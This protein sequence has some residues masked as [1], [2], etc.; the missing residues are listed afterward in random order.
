MRNLARFVAIPMMFALMLAVL[1]VHPK[2]VT[3]GQTLGTHVVPCTSS[4]TL[5]PSYLAEYLDL[6]CAVSSISIPS[7]YGGQPYRLTVNSDGG[8]LGGMPA[9]MT[10]DFTLSA[11]YTRFDMKYDTLTAIWSSL[12]VGKVI[13]T[14]VAQLADSSNY[15]TTSQVSSMAPV[16]SVNGQTGAVAI[17][18]TKGDTGATGPAGPQGA[19]G[20]AGANGVQGAT[21]PS[22]SVGAT[23][24]SGPMGNAG[25]PGPTGASGATGSAGASG[26]AGPTGGVGPQGVA[27]A[28]GATGAQGLVGATGA[29]GST[30]PTGSVG[31]IGATGPTGATGNI[32]ATGLQGMAGIQGATGLAGATGAAGPTGLSG[33]TGSTGATGSQ[34]PSGTTG[35]TGATGASGIGPFSTGTWPAWLT[36]SVANSSTTPTLSVA[37]SAIPNSA[38][39][40]SSVTI[41]GTSCTLGSS[42]TVKDYLSGTTGVITGTLLALGGQDTGTATVTGATAGTPC[43]ASTTDGTNPSSSVV[44]SCI[45]TAANTAT[46]YET[47]LAAGTPLSKAFNIRVF[48]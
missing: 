37:A 31:P 10:G 5:N 1:L 16:Q 26:P 36:P 42:C 7:G 8:S 38:L 17:T 48:P 28:V 40:S 19:Q 35:A 32:G 14:T 23:G 18:L 22:G 27:G 11:T 20:I 9:N 12:N 15:A 45:V 24:S 47:A 34:G 41:D 25:P 44:V 39:A 3:H 21:G 4:I 43:V 46:V 13:P 29:T 6:T 30:G 33:S 2:F